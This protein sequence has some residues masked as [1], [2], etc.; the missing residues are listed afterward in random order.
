MMRVLV[1]SHTVFSETNNMGKTLLTYFE[2]FQPNEVAQFYVHSEVPTVDSVCHRYYRFTD[3]DAIK[4]IILPEIQGVGF[5][6]QDIQQG[7]KSSRTDIGITNKLY[8]LGAKRT[9][10]IFWLRNMVW[11]LSRWENRKLW[12]WVDDFS[13]DVVLFAAGDYAF[14]YDIAR[15]IAEHVRKPLVIA[16]VDDFFF[17]NKNEDSLLGRIVHKHFMK[18]V[19][20]TMDHAAEI[21]TICDSMQQEYGRLFHKKCKVLYTAAQR[22]TLPVRAD[23]NQISYIGN[24]ELG[25]YCQ[26]IELGQ[27]LCRI[28]EKGYPDAIDVYSMEKDPQILKHLTLENGI[29][30]HGAISAE[31]VQEV[32]RSSMAVI[33]TES[34]DPKIMQ[35]IRFSVSTKIAESLMNGPCLIAYGPEGIAS[36]DYLKENGAAYTITDPKQLETGLREILTNAQ[37]REQIVGR[38]RELAKANHSMEVNPVNV[39][40]WLTQ[41]CE[42]FDEQESQCAIE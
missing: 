8:R 35:R 15:E 23:S 21:L 20:R 4:S 37:L 32:M 22:G 16:C 31:Q 42:E 39:R 25:R 11:K 17:Y 27:T 6:V 26:L 1:V 38:A 30:F 28:R 12:K 40:K 24:L 36:I 29:R 18:T 19:H 34:F 33:H 10:G 2:K 9:A 7:R 5:G 3:K 41:A 14:M 13:P